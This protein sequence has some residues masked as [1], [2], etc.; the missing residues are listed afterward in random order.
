MLEYEG[1]F[2]WVGGVDDDRHRGQTAVFLTYLDRYPML[3]SGECVAKR[4]CDQFPFFIVSWAVTTV[5]EQ[6]MRP[7]RA[8]APK[9]SDAKSIKECANM[10]TLRRIC[11]LSRPLI[12][13]GR[14]AREPI[15]RVYGRMRFGSSRVWDLNRALCLLADIF[16]ELCRQ[17]RGLPRRSRLR[18]SRIRLPT[19]QEEKNP[20]AGV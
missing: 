18:S 5:G 8:C 4:V 1:F 12:S 20:T 13:R 2:F 6:C 10:R 7:H 16:A 17:M 3:L 9:Y 14:Q 19:I 11:Q 15:S